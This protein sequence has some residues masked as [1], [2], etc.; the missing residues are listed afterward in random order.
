MQALKESQPAIERYSRLLV[1]RGESAVPKILSVLRQHHPHASSAKLTNYLI[2]LYCPVVKAN[3]SLS[4]R[5]KRTRLKHFS[6]S[7]MVNLAEPR[8]RPRGL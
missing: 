6:S 5:Q 1:K 4:E 3:A 2:T 8:S 7:L